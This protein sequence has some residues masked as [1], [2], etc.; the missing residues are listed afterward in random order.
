MKKYYL[1]I[2]FIF[3]A[4]FLSCESEPTRRVYE[5]SNVPSYLSI[6]VNRAAYSFTIK[7]ADSVDHRVVVDIL[8][9]RNSIWTRTFTVPANDILQSHMGTYGD[10]YDARV[11]QAVIVDWI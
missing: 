9:D 4:L 11:I 5:A 10:G 2:S 7:N 1:F 8:T 3:F 6:I